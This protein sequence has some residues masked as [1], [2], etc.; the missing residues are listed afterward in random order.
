MSQVEMGEGSCETT[1]SCL[2]ESVTGKPQSE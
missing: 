2:W 1:Q